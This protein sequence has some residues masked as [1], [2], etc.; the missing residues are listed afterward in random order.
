[1]SDVQLQKKRVSKACD[2]CRARKLKCD[3]LTPSCSRCQASKV[4]CVYT[5][6]EKRPKKVV[7]KQTAPSQPSTLRGLEDRMRRMESMI[8]SLVG[9][10]ENAQNLVGVNSNGEPNHTH[11]ENGNETD[12]NETSPEVQ[13]TDDEP[14]IFTG[15]PTA[16]ESSVRSGSVSQA[17]SDPHEDSHGPQV[18][19]YFGSQSTMSVLSVKGML[20]LQRFCGDPGLLNRFQQFHKMTTTIFLMANRVWFDPPERSSLRKL[21]PREMVEPL[22]WDV[23]NELALIQLFITKEEVDNLIQRYYDNVAMS[24]KVPNRKRLSNSDLLTLNSMVAIAFSLAMKPNLDKK[25]LDTF[26]TIQVEARTNAVFYYQRLSTISEGIRTIQG[27]MILTL[28]AELM[29]CSP[30]TYILISTLVR[31]AQEMGLH[32]KESFMGLS[33]Q[34]AMLR[35]RIWICVYL[36]D[37]GSCLKSGKPPIIHRKDVSSITPESY[38]EVLFYGVPSHQVDEMLS[39]DFDLVRALSTMSSSE[40]HISP[41]K[42]LL[43]YYHARIVDFT[44]VA[45]ECLFCGDSLVG[46][47]LEQVLKRVDEMDGMLDQNLMMMM[48]RSARPGADLSSIREHG[49]KYHLLL[50][51][52]YYHSLK[53]VINKMAFTKIWLNSNDP[54]SDWASILPEQKKLMLRCLE[55][56]RAIM[57]FVQF[58]DHLNPLFSNYA[59][60]QFMSAFFTLFTGIIE[61]PNAPFV[62]HDL[63]MITNVSNKLLAKYYA[64]WENDETNFMYIVINSCVRFFMRI[65][66]MVRNRTTPNKIDLDQVEGQLRSFE[67]QMSKLA[68]SC[69]V[70]LRDSD[71]LTILLNNSESNEM[72]GVNHPTAGIFN[73]PGAVANLAR[74]RPSISMLMNPVPSSQREE[75]HLF[76]HASNDRFS[77]GNIDMERNNSAQSA[78]ATE[79][80]TLSHTSSIPDVTLPVQDIT[81]DRYAMEQF[82]M[83]KNSSILQHIFTIPDMFLSANE[84]ENYDLN[85]NN[86]HF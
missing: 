60:F 42:N 30:Q 17:S 22:I 43:F 67:N 44:A 86:I 38:R 37:C 61:Y 68:A 14:I 31:Y 66:V 15:L 35:R 71:P 79:G 11:S 53:M 63:E 21:P 41:V 29:K 4:T 45:Y 64:D 59:S 33:E 50:S 49:I 62:E 27:L 7:K 16:P 69:A 5:T 6:K 58:E 75:T 39:P 36:M 19:K 8:T 48:P 34:E 47:S 3:A 23:F 2:I 73:P 84:F 32:R 24:N 46:M 74:E 65:A 28:Y 82:E 20:W 18:A 40:F 1:M 56:A 12:E 80:Q 52:L 77:P 57:N 85:S 81:I 13:N 10:L 70:A 76:P 26:N 54:P 9:K 72:Q 25:T 51:H 55:S 83:E 78:V